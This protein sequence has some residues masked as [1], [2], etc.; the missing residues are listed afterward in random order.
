M[1]GG[2]IN[3]LRQIRQ[4]MTN[5]L[6]EN[7][8]Q[9]T[10]QMQLIHAGLKQKNIQTLPLDH[11]AVIDLPSHH[12]GISQLS[13]LFSLLGYSEQGKGY[14]P[15]K[16]NDFLWMA[17]TDY[18][19]RPAKEA[20]PQVVVADFRLEEFPSEIRRI[21]EKYTPSIRPAPI[22]AV[23]RLVNDVT[24]GDTRAATQLINLFI[25]Y[26]AGREWPLPTV[27]DFRTV[28]EFN[29][30]IA[31][32]LVFGRRPNHFTVSVHH[33]SAFKSIVEFHDFIE[34]ELGLE[35]NHEGG[36]IKGG[37]ETGISQGSTAGLQ[38][39]IT[40]IDGDVQ[41]PTGFVEFI[42]RYPQEKAC[43][44]PLLWDDY[45][46]GFIPQYADRVIESLYLNEKKDI[47]IEAQ[48]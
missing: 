3:M 6:W 41:L 29:E 44:N 23:K 28:Q 4:N 15:D 1:R 25:A 39:T 7:Y 20:L 27:H 5:A 19:N 36:K 42:W 37:V 24:H 9:S 40:L 45:F 11:Y 48:G 31:W 14:L 43:Q 22:D 17:E 18:K 2:T 46:T 16:Q 12:S 8:C 33:L 30:L 34:H 10:V 47:L 26:L 38:Q 13:Q 35:M 32:V 21:V